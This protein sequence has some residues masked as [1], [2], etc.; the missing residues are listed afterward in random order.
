MS[1]ENGFESQRSA[2]PT[3]RGGGGAGVVSFSNNNNNNNNNT[4]PH[5]LSLN[6]PSTPYEERVIPALRN[7]NR[8]R[9]DASS[10]T[11][12]TAVRPTAA[13]AIATVQENATDG[14]GGGGGGGVGGDLNANDLAEALVPEQSESAE[15]ANNVGD[16]GDQVDGLEEMSEK[17]VREAALMIDYLGKPIVLKLYSKNFQHREEAI[18][19][20]YNNLNNV[21]AGD[22]DEARTLM[23]ATGTLLTKMCKDNVFSVFNSSIRLFQFLVDEFARRHSLAKNEIN[24]VLESVLPVLIHRTGDTNAR[25]RQKAHD[26]IVDVSTFGDVKPLHTVPNLCA[27]PI[28]LHIAPRLALSRVEL[29]ESLMRQLGSKDNGLTCDVI[30]KFCAQAL[31]HT[32]GEVRELATKLL[33][34]MYRVRVNQQQSQN[35]LNDKKAVFYF[36]IDGIFHICA[37]LVLM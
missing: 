29:I 9:L 6:K 33:T 26:C 25:S 14:G 30:S 5:N 7:T 21:K 17:E 28:K 10:P 13:A 15:N 20:V 3:N 36:L 34:Q 27:Q 35:I 11:G 32:S 24:N 16:F 18:Q 37:I 31:E 8:S 22:K 2:R 12:G 23:R 19:E 4:S 1:G